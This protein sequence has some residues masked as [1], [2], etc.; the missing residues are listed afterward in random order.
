MWT[1]GNRMEKARKVRG[2]NQDDLAIYLGLKKSTISK[3]ER[4]AQIPRLAYIRSWA[5][6]CGVPLEWLVG[7]MQFTADGGDNDIARQRGLTKWTG[8]ILHSE[9]VCA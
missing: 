8:A 1:L 2:L 4:G 6:L 9:A 3:F 7:D 5:E